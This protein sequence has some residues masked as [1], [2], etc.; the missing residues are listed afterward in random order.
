MDIALALAAE[1]TDRQ[2]PI[3]VDDVWALASLLCN[4]ECL[5]LNMQMGPRGF[6]MAG[7][8]FSDEFPERIGTVVLGW[9]RLEL[10]HT[11][12]VLGS[13]AAEAAG[14]LGDQ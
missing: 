8:F 9:T 11:R 5:D 7:T 3:A 2:N 1:T 13:L 10:A 12:R 4:Q 14:L 6:N